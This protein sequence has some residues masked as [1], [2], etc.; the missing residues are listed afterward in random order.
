[1]GQIASGIVQTKF[2]LQKNVMQL[3][4]LYGITAPEGPL[5]SMP[6]KTLSPPN[7]TARVPAQELHPD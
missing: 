6:A 1:M 3:V 5:A 4:Q 2:D 7:S